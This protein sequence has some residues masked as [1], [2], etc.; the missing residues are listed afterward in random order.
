MISVFEISPYDIQRFTET[1]SKQLESWA[2]LKIQSVTPAPNGN[3]IA[4]IEGDYPCTLRELKDIS[5]HK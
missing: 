1:A 5:V 2:T 4:V 3:F